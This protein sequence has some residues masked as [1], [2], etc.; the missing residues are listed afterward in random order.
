[1]SSDL[2]WFT[3]DRLSA[4][5]HT[6]ISLGSRHASDQTAGHGVEWTK[7][8]AVSN[9]HQNTI[10]RFLETSKGYYI[11]VRNVK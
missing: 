8:P 4:L 6:F 7:Y 5:E 3:V 1:M 9:F 10:E 11:L 2:I